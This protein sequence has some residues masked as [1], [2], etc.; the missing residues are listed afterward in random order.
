[1]PFPISKEGANGSSNIS[2]YAAWSPS[3][4]GFAVPTRTNGTISRTVIWKGLML[5]IAIIN[6]D[7]TRQATI[8]PDG[9]KSV[10]S[11]N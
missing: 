11:T 5:E 9:P 3:G 6:K 4:S 7:W 10:G 1:M 2:C 8:S